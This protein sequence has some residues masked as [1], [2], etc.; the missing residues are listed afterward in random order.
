MFLFCEIYYCYIT[1]FMKNRK[2]DEWRHCTYLT[3]QNHLFELF[4]F[5]GRKLRQ[6]DGEKCQHR[7]SAPAL[8]SARTGHVKFVQRE[9]GWFL[10]LR[11][12]T[13]IDGRF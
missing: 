13:E 11:R 4:R 1:F 10:D 12:L 7:G 6:R 9:L 2:R 3:L 8:H 5:G